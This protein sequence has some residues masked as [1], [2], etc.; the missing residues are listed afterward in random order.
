MFL[1]LERDMVD[2][3]PWLQFALPYL[4]NT[5]MLAWRETIRAW[6]YIEAYVNA[7]IQYTVETTF[8]SKLSTAW[9]QARFEVL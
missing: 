5:H 4:K 8:H 3:T 9:C 2:T 6:F 1:G 7:N